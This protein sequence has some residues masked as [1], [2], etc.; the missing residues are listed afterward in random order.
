MISTGSAA[1]RPGRLMAAEI[2][3]QPAAWRRLLAEG[4]QQLDAAAR[5]LTERRP[6]F[7]LLLA[8]GTSD[9]AALYA[10]HLVEILL[11]LPAGLVSPSTLTAYQARPDLRDVVVVAVSQSGGSPD[12]V[13]SLEVARGQGALTLAVTNNPSS[14]LAESKIK[15]GWHATASRRSAAQPGGLWW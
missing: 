6:R 8:R 3:E 10:K 4:T 2:G 5:L 14:A 12:L 7:V 9:H 15:G 1:A 11:Q 13:Q